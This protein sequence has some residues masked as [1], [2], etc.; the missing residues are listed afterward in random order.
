MLQ[1][2]TPT[3]NL[4]DSELEI[5]NTYIRDVKGNVFEGSV[6]KF[7]ITD[8]DFY[9]ISGHALNLKGPGEIT[10]TIFRNIT[11]SAVKIEND[12][13]EDLVIETTE[14]LGCSAWYGGAIYATNA[15]MMV[16]DSNFTDNSANL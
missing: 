3:F 6:T 7:K 9:K 5:F 15:H 10:N 1:T 16:K 13:I 14:F 12:A 11:A 2:P 4:D 8:S